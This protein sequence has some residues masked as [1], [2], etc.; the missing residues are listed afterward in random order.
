[1]F[2]LINLMAI[3]ILI[4]NLVRRRSRRAYTLMVLNLLAGIMMRIQNPPIDDILTFQIPSTDEQYKDSFQKLKS[5]QKLNRI[6]MYFY[7]DFFFMLFLA[8]FMFEIKYSLAPLYLVCD[9]T[10]TIISLINLSNEP[11]H[12]RIF[13]LCNTVKYSTVVGFIGWSIVA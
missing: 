10:E 3:M 11:M 13:K 4:P 7:L 2:N 12:Y 9:L 1:M 6:K 8:G 5:S